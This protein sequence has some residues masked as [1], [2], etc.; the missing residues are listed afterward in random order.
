LRRGRSSVRRPVPMF[1]IDVRVPAMKH[2]SVIV[3]LGAALALALA[4][5]QIDSAKAGE[6][7]HRAYAATQNGGGYASSRRRRLILRDVPAKMPPPPT[8]F[9]PHFDFPTEPL[10]G[11]LSHDP[12]PN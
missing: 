9:G 7:R 4:T 6:W 11:G 10:N 5:V 2:M 1:Q 8:D 3:A 12:Y